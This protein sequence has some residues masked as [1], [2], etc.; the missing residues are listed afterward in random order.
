MEN[1]KERRFVIVSG[2]AAGAPLEPVLSLPGG[3]TE[4]DYICCADG[5]YTRCAAEGICPDIVIGDFDS[6]SLEEVCA[7][8][9]STEVYPS[10]KDDTDTMLCVKNGLAKGFE[11]FTIVGGLGGEFSHTMANIQTLSFLTDLECEAEI[12]TTGERLFMVDGEAVR[13]GREPKPA[14]PVVF[15]GRPGAK[16]SVFSYA[17]RS[18]GVYI[19]NAKYELCGAVLTQSYPIGVRNEFID[20][21]VVTV[22]VRFGRLLV[23][24]E[25]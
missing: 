15:C 2:Q 10:A 3:I 24:V 6:V 9:V 1:N 13:V 5:G 7:A 19:Q 21:E 22:S 18:S 20:E 16:F 17:E 23:V 25:R 12:V 11:R 4:D 8:G 14:T